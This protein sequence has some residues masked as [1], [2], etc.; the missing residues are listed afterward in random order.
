MSESRA[1]KSRENG[2]SDG[3]LFVWRAWLRVKGSFC[4][5]SVTANALLPTHAGDAMP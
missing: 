1:E 3:V 5:H 4:Q 2:S